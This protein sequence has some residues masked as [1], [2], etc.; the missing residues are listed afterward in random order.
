MPRYN[1]KLPDGRWRVFSSIC[2]DYVTEPMEF[3]DLKSWRRF[4]YGAQG[5]QTDRESDSL[6]ADKPLV[7]VMAYEDA[8][9]MRSLHHEE[10]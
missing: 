1:V 4:E 3:V 7:N 8:E 9:Y 5:G 6:L 10:H 2:D